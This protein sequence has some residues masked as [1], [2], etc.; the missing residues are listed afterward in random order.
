MFS[1]P[2]L[3]LVDLDFGVFSQ[4][5]SPPR[6]V[7]NNYKPSFN[8]TPISMS[9]SANSLSPV[10]EGN[11]EDN[12]GSLSLRNP[13]FVPVIATSAAPSETFLKLT[14]SGVFK[15]P[16]EE[17]LDVVDLELAPPDGDRR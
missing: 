13:V 8:H 5:S 10:H 11:E 14:I 1:A 15:N 4:S 16:A 17:P 2:N 7:L 6:E 9:R 12:G 3:S